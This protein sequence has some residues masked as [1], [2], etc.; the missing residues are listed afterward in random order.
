MRLILVARR[1]RFEAEHALPDMPGYDERH[2]HRYL[3]EVVLRS[4]PEPEFNTDELDAAW[5]RLQPKHR[6]FLND[7][8]LDT[9]VEGLALA[10]FEALALEFSDLLAVSVCEDDERWGRVTA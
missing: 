2:A 7:T 1:Y 4:R 9:T 10:W 5:A 6:A 8:L 3:V